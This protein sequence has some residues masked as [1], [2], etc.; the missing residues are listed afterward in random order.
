MREGEDRNRRCILNNSFVDDM[1]DKARWSLFISS[2]LRGRTN[3]IKT[4]NIPAQ[5][6]DGVRENN[7]ESEDASAIIHSTPRKG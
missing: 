3:I 4:D 5:T 2:H 1:V 7:N 6:S